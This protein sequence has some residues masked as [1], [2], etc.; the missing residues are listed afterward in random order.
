MDPITV[1]D[2]F[3]DSAIYPDIQ[4]VVGEFRRSMEESVAKDHVLSTYLPMQ[5]VDATKCKLFIEAEDFGTLKGRGLKNDFPNAPTPGFDV[6][7]YTP[8]YFGEKR[9]I[10]EEAALKIRQIGTE[11]KAAELSLETG[12]L[13]R[14]TRNRTVRLM[15]KMA[16]DLLFRGKVEVRDDMDQLVYRETLALP[17]T[18]VG[19]SISD[20]ANSTPVKYFLDL[21]L[22]QSKHA[23]AGEYD[24]G[25]DSEIL[26]GPEIEAALMANRNNNDLWGYFKQL[27]IIPGSMTAISAVF[28]ALG[29]PRLVSY[30]GRY[31][32]TATAERGLFGSADTVLW[33]GA[34]PD[35]GLKAGMFQMTRNYQ[36]GGK[37][38]MWASVVPDPKGLFPP[39]V[40][41]GF[42]GGVGIYDAYQSY[43][44]K[45]IF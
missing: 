17:E 37:P 4:D 9:N 26:V 36:N 32:D 13:L 45:V 40:Y 24:W 15:K 31:K 23:R 39:E 19:T 18:T 10:S 6:K 30:G 29:L 34:Q 7:E 44:V 28:Q 42:N 41:G 14:I 12:R 22:A 43:R 8:G 16:C 33:V 21:K 11:D 3:A 25:L 20:G 1:V 2:V 5:D 38:G 27:N 35:R